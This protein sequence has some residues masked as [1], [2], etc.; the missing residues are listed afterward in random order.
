MDAHRQ[1]E[2][3]AQ[4]EGIE[5]VA[6]GFVSRAFRADGC[7]SEYLESGDKGGR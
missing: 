4:D 6:F 2:R 5:L 1:A 7:T 3:K